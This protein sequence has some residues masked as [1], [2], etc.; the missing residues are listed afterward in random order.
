MHLLLSW[1]T[2]ALGFW[3]T[4]M[5]VPGFKVRDFPS[6]LVVSAVFGVLHFAIGWFLFGVIGVATLFIG[7]IFAFVTRWIV[8]AIVLKITDALTES[9]EIASFKTALVGSAVL[10]VLTFVR[11][12]V[13]RF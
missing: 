2:L 1:L 6:A 12:A 11:E 7:F 5:L 4:S 8:T 13:L 10:S 9:L 3:I